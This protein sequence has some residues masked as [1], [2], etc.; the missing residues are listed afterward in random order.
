MSLVAALAF[1]GGCRITSASPDTTA[2]I[3]LKPGQT[4]VFAVEGIDL[5]LKNYLPL[6]DEVGFDWKV[7]DDSVY[8]PARHALGNV[9]STFTYSPSP[10][11]AGIN[12]IEVRLGIWHTPLD[13]PICGYFSDATDSRVWT[14]E[15][16]GIARDPL[17]NHL[18][19]AQGTTQPLAVEPCPPEGEY[20]YQWFKDGSP[21][22]DATTASIIFT[23]GPGD[24]CTHI[25]GVE[26][27]GWDDGSTFTQAWEIEVS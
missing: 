21:I 23:P 11:D 12:T 4:Q 24:I 8:V 27:A 26:A 1:L 3:V 9:S 18:V 15:V 20:T 13:C 5:I 7:N 25:I 14:V 16:W 19:M 22:P 10:V 2:R 17:Q 6:F